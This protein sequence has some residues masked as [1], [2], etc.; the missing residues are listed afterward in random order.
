LD[1]GTILYSVNGSKHDDIR[2][3]QSQVIETKD[4]TIMCKINENK[5]IVCGRIL[6]SESKT[7]LWNIIWHKGHTLEA[8]SSLHCMACPLKRM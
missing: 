2:N 3:K 5:T 8:I 6:V 1:K 4:I 7:R